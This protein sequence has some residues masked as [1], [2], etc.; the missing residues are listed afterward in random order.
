MQHLLQMRWLYN[1]DYHT[2][3]LLVKQ[4][5]LLYISCM[6]LNFFLATSYSEITS[7]LFVSKHLTFTEQYFYIFLSYDIT[8]YNFKHQWIKLLLLQNE[9][10]SHKMITFLL[11][12]KVT[13]GCTY[14][15]SRIYTLVWA[16]WFI[17]MIIF[18]IFKLFY[19]CCVSNLQNTA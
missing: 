18:D 8:L 14:N 11:N 19:D 1:I 4:S 16:L 3:K 5:W 17:Y 13:Q 12:C 9:I 7:N 15:K 6:I 10:K 2:V